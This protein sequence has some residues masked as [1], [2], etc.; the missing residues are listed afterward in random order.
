MSFF[1]CVCCSS[2]IFSDGVL[3]TRQ[4][5]QYINV[6]EVSLALLYKSNLEFLLF[7]KILRIVFCGLFQ[8]V[9]INNRKKS[10]LSGAMSL[11]FNVRNEDCSMLVPD[12]VAELY[13][14]RASN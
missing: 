2:Y 14:F 8:S 7:L 12:A 11:S 1:M 5:Y 9:E 6:P 10:I 13:F 3:K 4:W